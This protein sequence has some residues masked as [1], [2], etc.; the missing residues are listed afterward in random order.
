MGRNT[1][2]S[3]TDNFNLEG[4]IGR[5]KVKAE[6]WHC[7]KQQAWNATRLVTHLAKCDNFKRAQTPKAYRDFLVANQLVSTRSS[8]RLAKRAPETPPLSSTSLK[9][10]ISL[11]DSFSEDSPPSGSDADQ[12]RARSLQ[13]VPLWIVARSRGGTD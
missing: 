12:R 4:H 11:F 1:N 9:S 8:P 2:I 13:A 10:A 6:C 3:V 5:A 7:K